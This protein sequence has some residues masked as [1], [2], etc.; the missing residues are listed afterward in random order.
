MGRDMGVTFVINH[1]RTPSYI[2]RGPES[3][4][5]RRDRAGS[6][7]VRLPK[8]RKVSREPSPMAGLLPRTPSSIKTSHPEEPATKDLAA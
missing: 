2:R 7:P 3:P 5:S 8:E 6:Q 4:L 1:P